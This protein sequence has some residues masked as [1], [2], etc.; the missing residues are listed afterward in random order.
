M[1][2]IFLIINVFA[3]AFLYSCE[4]RIEMDMTQWGDHAI[5]NNVQVFKYEVDDNPALY[6][7]VVGVGGVSGVRRI[8]ISDKATVDLENATVTVPLK[9]EETLTDAGLIFYHE[10]VKIEPLEGSPKGGH[11]G[12]LS[13]RL[14][15]YRLFSADGSTRDWKIVIE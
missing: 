14:A 3:L 11:T 15:E 4:P 7:T 8:I 6:E 2:K 9:G 1:N 12:D 10:S 13:G 5:I